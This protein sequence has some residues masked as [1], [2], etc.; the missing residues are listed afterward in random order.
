MTVPRL[1][2]FDLGGVVVRICRGWDEACAAA[3]IDARPLRDPRSHGHL[4]APVVHAH[5]RGAMECDRYAAELASIVGGVTAQE[6]RRVHDAWILGDYPG[7]AQAIDRIHAA[8]VDTAC[9]SNTDASHWEQLH[10]SDAFRRIRRRHASHLLGLVKPDAAIYRAFERHAGAA[11]ADIVFFDD[12]P[13]NVDAARACGWNAVQ[14]D[15]AGDT[16]AQ[17]LDALRALG[18]QA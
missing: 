10:S 15:H 12:L 2:V 8:G 7:I 18:V 4:I 6:A 5:Q 16:A 14:V 1:V 11:P 9:L 3:G 13:E 17:V